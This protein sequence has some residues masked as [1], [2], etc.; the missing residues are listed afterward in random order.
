MGSGALG[1]GVAMLLLL[2][3]AAEA[4]P[5]V[6]SG[7]PRF[8]SLSEGLPQRGE[9]RTHPA[10]RDVNGD[11]HPDLSALPNRER[12]PGVWLFAAPGRWAAASTGL[13]VPGDA[14]G[15]GVDLADVNG[16]GHLDLGVA[17]HCRGLFVFLGDGAG[18][19]RLGA[20]PYG[21]TRGHED[22]R[23]G[24][25]TG[26]GRA[27]LVAV[28]AR[29]GGL[30]VFRGDG[31]GGFERVEVGLPGG[32]G[33]DVDLG[34]VDRDGHLDIAAAFVAAEP[35]PRTPAQRRLPVVW[36]NDGSGRFRTA[37]EGLPDDGSFRSV[38][39]G[40]ADGDGLLDLA[41]ASMQPRRA[42]LLVYLNTGGSW[43]APEG[44]HPDADRDAAIGG[45]AFADFDRDGHLDLAGVDRFAAGIRLWR[46][47]GTGRFHAC[48]GTGL[49]DARA[50]LRAWGL[51]VAD[52][53][54]D[55]RPDIAAGFAGAEAGGL[56]V[57]AQR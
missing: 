22:L 24:D 47:D 33:L 29:E 43:R 53:D 28:A 38:A 31:R 44:G 26:D 37:S 30:P 54:A 36:R 51:A 34:D 13:V 46:G 25:L 45:I 5:Q 50:P 23:F 3:L 42:P 9:W 27:D 18:R 56:E 39:L 48:K 6:D 2:G 4:R 11:G 55:G 52:V 40:D 49:P 15:G 21:A 10:L 35:D 8:A 7:C 20:G 16:D 57:W 14:C 41:L 1:A 12:G 17:D 32:F 19:W